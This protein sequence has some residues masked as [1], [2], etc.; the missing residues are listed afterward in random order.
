MKQS[1]K[2][3]VLV[4]INISTEAIAQPLFS[5]DWFSHHIN[6][7]DKYKLFFEG[8]SNLRCLEIGSYEGRSTLYIAENYCKYEDSVIY[9]L[10][11][12]SGSMEHDAQHEKNLFERFSFNLKDL[13]NKGR[14]IPVREKSQKTLVDFLNLVYQND[15]EKFDFI[16]IDGSHVAKDV[17]S[18]IV[19][20]WELLKPGGIL[21]ADD[22]LWDHYKE[23]RLTP[24]PALDGFLESYK[25]S[26]EI[27]LKGYQVH[28]K[29]IN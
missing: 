22:Y 7:W 19:L 23:P 15:F 8:K 25:G 12:W 28:L 14:V 17:M 9:A 6:N 26:Y 20:A 24:K 11:T 29:K 21:I 13:V 2:L 27:L 18:D 3:L 16:Y 4:V 1:I 10:D 5:A